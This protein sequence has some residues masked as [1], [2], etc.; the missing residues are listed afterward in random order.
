MTVTTN[1][2]LDPNESTHTHE[3][4]LDKALPINETESTTTRT[5]D[6]AGTGGPAGFAAQQPN[7]AVALGKGPS[8]GSKEEENGS[9]T[10][11][12]SVP[13]GKQ[14]DVVKLGL[15]PIMEKASI[16]IPSSYFKKAWQLENPSAAG[17]EPKVPDAAALDQFRTKTIAKVKKQVA[18]LLTTPEG[19]TD[20]MDLVEVTDFQEIPVAMPP[21]PSLAKNAMLWLGDYWS[22]AG[23]ICLAGV[24]LAMLRSL[25]KSAPPVDQNS[26][27]RLADTPEEETEAAPYK[28]PPVRVRRFSTGPSLRDEISVLVKE[29]PETAANILKTW[30]GHAG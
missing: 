16:G 12:L 18:M 8:G 27:P 13:S 23:M 28:P 29:D 24:S 17:Q 25:I 11:T 30:I 3:I 7:Q 1:V 14:T 5:A 9:K 6:T 19:N 22:V 15:T 26:M 10:V 2:I 21:E 20:P 4:K